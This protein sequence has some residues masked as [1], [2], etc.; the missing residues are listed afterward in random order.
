MKIFFFASDVMYLF[1][2][3]HGLN[4]VHGRN[5]KDLEGSYLGWDDRSGTELSEVDH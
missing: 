2:Q 1:L 4:T 3:R 5:R